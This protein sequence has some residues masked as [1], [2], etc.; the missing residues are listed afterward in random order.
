MLHRYRSLCAPLLGSLLLTLTAALLTTPPA[1]PETPSPTPQRRM[2][3]TFDDLPLGY[4]SDR[5]YG[6]QRRVTEDLL[7]L[8]AEHE[9]PAI[10]FVNEEK[11]YPGKGPDEGGEPAPRRVALLER[12]LEAGHRLGNHTYSHP[13]L[14]RV[15]LEDF[16]QD[17]LLG[18]KVLR[19]LVEAP[20]EGDP[21]GDGQGAEL[22][23]RHPFLHTGR[24]LEVKRG[25][26]EFLARHGYRVAP[27]TVDNS[28]WIFALAYDRALTAGDG[29]L[30]RRV[31]DAYAPYL[32]EKVAFFEGNSRDLFGREIPQVLLLHANR[33]NAD[34]F[35]RVAERL[36]A[37][38]YEFVSLEEALEDPAYD[39]PDAYTGPGG[40]TW[41]HR[42]ALTRGVEESFFRG[43]P[44]VPAFVLEAG[45]M[46]SE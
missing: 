26:E 23:F 44:E 37:R 4:A 14:H 27:V 35:G 30:A 16:Q 22:F 34:H 32:E 17:V 29:E 5:S 38:G 13:D 8:L 28:E 31:A 19:R 20:G 46:E 15:P 11:L 2:A 43:E 9:V 7:A 21:S 42:W 10:G 6:M 40:I 18:E 33:L 36:K 45:G 12:W 24:S 3:V 1:Q 25:L 41:L 39:S